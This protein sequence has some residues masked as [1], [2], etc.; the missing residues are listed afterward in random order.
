VEL[1]REGITQ[2]RLAVASSR[3]GSNVARGLSH[4]GR[5]RFLKG[6][7]LRLARD[8]LS[9]CL[10]CPSADRYAGLTLTGTRLY[11]HAATNS[12]QSRWHSTSVRLRPLRLPRAPCTRPLR[13]KRCAVCFG[14]QS[15]WMP[16]DEL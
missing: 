7:V 13:R 15:G 6:D 1:F 11:H 8:I 3:N 10:Q 5:N 14:L 9:G 12:S 4:V 16:R 2:A